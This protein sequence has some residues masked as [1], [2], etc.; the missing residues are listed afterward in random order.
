M[1][2]ETVGAIDR[3]G[4]GIVDKLFLDFGAACNPSDDDTQQDFCNYGPAGGS[5]AD[6]S[7]SAQ[8]NHSVVQNSAAG[9]G[10][11]DGKQALTAKD[12]LSYY[13]LWNRDQKDFQ[14]RSSVMTPKHDEAKPLPAYAS[15]DPLRDI[16]EMSNN[17]NGMERDYREG[18]P[19]AKGAGDKAPETHVVT[20]LQESE[21]DAGNSNR[22][23]NAEDSTTKPTSRRQQNLPSWAHGAYTVRFAGSEFVQDSS[24]AAPNAA[25]RCGVVWI[26]GEDAQSMEAE[27]DAELYTH[28]AAILQEFPALALP[29]QFKIHRST[30]GTDP[31]F[32]GSYSYG[33]AAAV[34]GECQALAQPLT[35][36][37]EPSSVGKIRL[38]FA[39]EACHPTYFGCTHGAYLTGQSQARRLLESW[40]DS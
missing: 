1:P 23:T 30:W 2:K 39:G 18:G 8:Q 20:G 32:R 9:K 27:S 13:L 33:S 31:L 28:V 7:K 34:G 21:P 22:V 10:Q 17:V 6:Q 11:D 15:R 35:V 5:N 19:A 40:N 37:T 3:L 12:A 29:G 38:L 4:F 14:P 26:T 24:A 25:N 36:Q 16:N